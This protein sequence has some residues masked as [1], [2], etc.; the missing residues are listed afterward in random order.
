MVTYCFYR[1]NSTHSYAIP[2]RAAGARSPLN[3]RGGGIITG[4]GGTRDRMMARPR[5]R[6]RG[7]GAPL[8]SS[9]TVTTCFQCIF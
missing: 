2:A 6:A 8:G 4:R 1:S 7:A 5:D 3:Q 9:G